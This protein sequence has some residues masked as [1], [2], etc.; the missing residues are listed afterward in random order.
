MFLNNLLSQVCPPQGGRFVIS[1][2]QG[3]VPN[4][5]VAAAAAAA[6]Q[7]QHQQQFTAAMYQQ[8]PHA[9]HQQQQ[10]AP[11]PHQQQIAPS[12][13]M[14]PNGGVMTSSQHLMTSPAS[15]MTSSQ[16]QQEAAAQPTLNEVAGIKCSISPKMENNEQSDLAHDNAILDNNFSSHEF[17]TFFDF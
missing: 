12:P 8:H 4:T 7:K 1:Q 3:A 9:M 13:H 16:S 5:A 14:P 6:Q 10:L 11:H 17:E 15:L 2:H